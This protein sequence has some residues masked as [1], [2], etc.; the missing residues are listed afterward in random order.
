MRYLIFLL[1]LTIY[2]NCY[3]IPENL[4]VDPEAGKRTPQIIEHWGYPAESHDVVTDDGYILTMHRI[5]HGKN[6]PDPS[7]KRPAVY[8]QHGLEA[9]S[10]NWI[11]NLPHLSFGYILADA[12]YDVWL[13]N[14]RG[15]LYSVGHTSLDPK[16]HPF[17]KFTWDEMQ[18]YDLPAMVDHIL[19]TT[20]NKEIYY[21]GHSQGTLIMFSHLAANPE[22]GQK[23]KKFFALAP[24]GTVKNIKGLLAVIAKDFYLE[25]EVLYKIFGEDQ[26]LPDSTFMKMMEKLF[27]SNAID[28]QVCDSLLFLIAGPE[29]KQMNAT[30]L[31]VYLSDEPSGTSTMNILHWAQMVRSG[32]QEMYDYGSILANEQHYGSK[33]PPIYDISKIQTDMYIYWSDADWLADEQDIQNH[34]FKEL[35]PKYIKEN[36]HLPNFNHLDFIWGQRA[37]EAIYDPILHTINLDSGLNQKK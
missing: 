4:K 10:S 25:F 29:S 17:W 6:D 21:V 14:V 33:T 5:P 7:K 20:G 12:G 15:N 22:F 9:S 18:K 3:K 34:L 23:I 13:G 16:K 37:A 30:R 31:P 1:F 2:V 36:V 35:N 19:T 27:C 11:S 26:F 8:L 28:E 24:V 32:K